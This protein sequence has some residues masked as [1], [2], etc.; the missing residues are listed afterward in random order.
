MNSGRRRLVAP[1]EFS[2][3]VDGAVVGERLHWSNWGGPAAT[4]VGAF[5]ERRFSSGDHVR[6]RST[7]R[8]TQLRV[9]RGA[10]YYTHAAMPIPS[11]PL[12]PRVKA[13]PTP[14]G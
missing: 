14:C 6:F 3:N 5:S 12:K 8:L 1:D 10:E 13:L 11:S 7:L 9:C 2:F 4:A